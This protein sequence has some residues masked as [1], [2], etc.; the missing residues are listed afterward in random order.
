M[1][2]DKMKRNVIKLYH[3]LKEIQMRIC[4]YQKDVA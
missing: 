1:D 2:D 4:Y 3:I